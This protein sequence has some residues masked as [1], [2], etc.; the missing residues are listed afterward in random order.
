MTT[1]TKDELQT[2]IRE[3]ALAL[4]R[5]GAREVYVFGSVASGRMREGSDV[6]MAVAGLPPEIFFEAMSQAHRVLGRSLDLIDLDE[7]TPFTRY[8]HEERELLRVE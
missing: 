8:L 4:K 6:D 7:P 2:R 5:F 1:T 3:A